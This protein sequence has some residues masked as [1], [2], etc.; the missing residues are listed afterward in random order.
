[1]QHVA[2]GTV[3]VYTLLISANDERQA[4]TLTGSY[5]CQ[6]EE[7]KELQGVR[8]LLLTYSLKG[9]PYSLPSPLPPEP[10]QAAQIYCRQ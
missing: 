6:G 7:R 3:K 8:L 4:A 5:E 1:M 2:R 9:E 10:L